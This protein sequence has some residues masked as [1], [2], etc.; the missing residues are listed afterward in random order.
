MRYTIS[1]GGVTIGETDLGFVR[2][3]VRI[4]AGWFHPNAEGER[5]LPRLLPPL[6]LRAHLDR[7]AWKGGL[8]ASAHHADAHPLVL[9]REDGSVVP[10]RMLGIQDTVE[11]LAAAEAEEARRES[12]PW[13]PEHDEDDDDLGPVAIALDD[14]EALLDG[15]PADLDVEWAPD[16]EPIEQPRYQII[17]ELVDD[18]AIP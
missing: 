2:S 6:A 16:E 11:L 13:T 8:A 12:L 7:D 3:A 17:L 5:L 1:S 10:T 9:H 18:G 14:D 4:R 15:D